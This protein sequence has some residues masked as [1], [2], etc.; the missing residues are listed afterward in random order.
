MASQERFALRSRFF[1]GAYW[2]SRTEPVEGCAGRLARC[3]P[4]LAEADPLLSTWLKVGRNKVESLRSGVDPSPE[5]LRQLLQESYDEKFPGLGFRF[6][7]WDGRESTGVA[8]SVTCG[9]DA[10]VSPNVFLINMPS[11]SEEDIR[12]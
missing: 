7:A 2:G 4:R 10:A 8:I 11:P 6:A 9:S 1:L 5:N 12:L 3:L